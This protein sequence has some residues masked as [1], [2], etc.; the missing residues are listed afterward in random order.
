MTPRVENNQGGITSQAQT[1]EV[2]AR[3]RPKRR[4]DHLDPAVSRKTV[5]AISEV[6][7]SKLDG[8]VDYVVTFPKEQQTPMLSREDIVLLPKGKRPVVQ[9]RWP[10]RPL[11]RSCPTTWCK[12]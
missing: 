8:T 11:H 5:G 2:G 9:L 6:L 12:K 10:K 7:V 3:V 4:L 1:L